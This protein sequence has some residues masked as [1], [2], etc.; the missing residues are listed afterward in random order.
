MITVVLEVQAAQVDQ[1]V[2]VVL[3][4][5]LDQARARGAVS[6]LALALGWALQS[7]W[8]WLELAL[9]L[10]WARRSASQWVRASGLGWAL[11]S[12]SK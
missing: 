5:Q 7:V 1:V 10:G 9:A 4:G 6:E 11:Q 3:G 2:Q 8:K 12:A